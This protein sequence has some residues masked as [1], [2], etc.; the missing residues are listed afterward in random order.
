MDTNQAQIKKTFAILKM[1]FF[2]TS[3]LNYL[4]SCFIL[5]SFL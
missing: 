1:S 4:K 2:K 3:L 5:V